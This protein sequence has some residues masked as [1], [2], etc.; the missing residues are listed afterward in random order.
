M[1]GFT[2]EWDRDF[3]AQGL[4]C[5]ETHI[6][7]VY[8]GP[9]DA[10]K[11]KK[12]VDLGYLDYS[13]LEKRKAACS[14]EVELN[15]RFAPSIYLGVVPIIKRDSGHYAFGGEGSPVDWAVHMVRL[16]DHDRA[17]RRLAERRL[18]PGA[19]K[20]LAER[21]AAFHAA[22]PADAGAAQNAAPEAIARNL[23]ENFIQTRAFSGALLGQGPC[24]ALQDRMRARLRTCAP[25][26]AARYQ[27]DRICDGHGDLRLCQIYFDEAGDSKILDCIEFNDRFRYG[28]TASDIAF[29]SMDLAF[30]G[31]LDLAEGF[32]AD[33]AEAS[34]D[35][36]LY[37]VV[38]YYQAY[39]ACVRGKVAGQRAAE[40]AMGPE[41]LAMEDEA[42]A[43]F[44]FAL[45]ERMLPDPIVIAIGGG[46]ATGKTTLAGR[47]G[48]LLGV[49]VVSTD[50]LR[51]RMAGIS[52]LE[53][54]HGRLWRGLY[55][56]EMTGRVYAEAARLAQ[57]IGDSGRSVIL[58]A[59][60]RTRA[61][62]NAIHEAANR[63]GRPFL[64]VE[65]RTDTE[66]CRQRLRLRTASPNPSDGNERLF[67]AFL[68]SWEPGD[69]IPP[70]QRLVLDTGSPMA[71]GVDQVMR[72]M[73]WMRARSEPA[74]PS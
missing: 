64:F 52:P 58:D 11:I 27:G 60:F 62:R 47:L 3:E 65:C 32:L 24:R 14:A 51:K 33:Y 7:K 6:S 5:E 10:W 67:Q 15:R 42:R 9:H 68:A 8:L 71:A 36:D 30:H 12:P 59:S 73:V 55:N 26:I 29:L 16:P 66:T 63:A 43:Y 38:D 56:P 28:D 19:F 1:N 23:E 49:P 13:S 20:A 70:T 69:D 22:F 39:R 34:G 61:S 37:S 45:A 74:I 25:A 31:H 57:V 4:Q 44:H 41:R 48:G 54:R 72:A 2:F 17:D 53:T 46:M 50:P 40:M 21:L 35:F 18:D